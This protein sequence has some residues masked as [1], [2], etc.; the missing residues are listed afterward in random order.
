V[1]VC[2]NTRMN[3]TH[4]DNSI[5]AFARLLATE[6]IRVRH[7]YDAE[8]AS[9][10]MVGRVLTLPRWKNMSARL[11]DMLVGHEV[12]HALF[13]D[14]TV[15]T[16]KNCLQA[17]VD[18]DPDNPKNAMP[19]LNIVEDA[20]IERLIKAKYPGLKRD[21]SAG[22]KQL[23]D[24]EIFPI[25]EMGG[26]SNMGILDRLNLHFKLGIL[27]ILDIPFHN[28]EERS[29]VDR[30]ANTQSWEDV[31]EVSRDLYQYALE[32]QSQTAQ[33]DLTAKMVADGEGEGQDGEGTATKPED[34]ADDSSKGMSSS[35]GDQLTSSTQDAFDHAKSAET[36]HSYNND[37]IEMTLPRI[38]R[39]KVV[40]SMQEI[41]DLHV[42]MPRDAW[43]KQMTPAL[44]TTRD[45]ILQHH[46]DE[47]D[48]FMNSE[49]STVT[50]L[51]KQFEMR[52]AADEHRRTS[53]HKSGRLDTVRMINHKWS[54]DIFAKN[55]VVRSGKNHGFVI[56]L[57]WSG[58]MQNNLMA[59][60]KQAIT[61]AMFCRRANIPFDLFA[62]TD[63]VQITNSD[64]NG[65]YAPIERSDY[66]PD[67]TNGDYNIENGS[68]FTHFHMLNFLTSKCN[69]R[70]FIQACRVLYSIAYTEAN[71][72]SYNNQYNTFTDRSLSLGGTPLEE[73]I[74]FLHTELPLFRKRHNV[75]VLNTVIL[76]DGESCGLNAVI[77]NPITRRTYGYRPGETDTNYRNNPLPQSF[78]LLKSL[79]EQ[80]GTNL[81]GMYL[82]MARSPT[83]RGIGHNWLDTYQTDAAILASLAKDWKNNR[84]FVAPGRY[85]QV[86][87]EAYVIDANLEPDSE[88][89]LP[90]SANATRTQ[91]RNAFVKGMKSRSMSR[92]LTNRFIEAIAS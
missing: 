10:D 48:S 79:K 71:A 54:E 15:N 56:V 83:A 27:G 87:D 77:H 86:F 59:T 11:Y 89:N 25:A 5:S 32:E 26:V 51:I 74:L 75:Q 13:T 65:N 53:I 91:L 92:L 61:L 69:N 72:Y 34:Q 85:S 29:F 24:M 80:T 76:T 33:N 57:D 8:T 90:D 62:F 73:A 44:K 17:C 36:K 45:S 30:L 68:D 6:N 66:Y 14:A 63:R 2:Y 55:A 38:N 23:Y 21:F 43:G 88:L 46:F 39:D 7:S 67:H 22:Y 3:T 9:F 18:I 47:C 50:N 35:K 84:F 78:L 20:R 49:K 12:A 37:P 40:V 1:W 19:V 41:H 52:K 4:H 16:E 70:D 28:D 42:N 64:D 81:I 31:I 82:T 60:V 58:S